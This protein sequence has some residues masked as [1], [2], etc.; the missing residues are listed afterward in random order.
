MGNRPGGML[1]ITFTV[2]WPRS[3]SRWATPNNEK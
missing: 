3:Q 1:M 2:P